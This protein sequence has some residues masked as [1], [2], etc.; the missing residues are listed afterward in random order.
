MQKVISVFG[1]S[2][3]VEES[4]A[5]L[6]AF[7]VGKQLAEAGYAVATG[8]Y[9]GTMG[10]VSHGAASVGGHVI[11]VT[12]GQIEAQFGRLP[13]Q[14]IAEEIKYP[15]LRERLFHL[16]LHND[17]MIALPGGIGT[18]SELSLAW[19]FMQTGEMGKRPFIL[20]GNS[21]RQT[22]EAFY[23]P[24]YTKEADLALVQYA[25]TAGECVALLKK[26]EG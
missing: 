25:E 14:W 17:G 18:L 4:E 11:G 22:I 6:T 12:S 24:E 8:G 20:L 9:Y 26:A 15:T 21:W 16:V 10:A 7:A 23:Q 19:S 5:Y 3:P 2:Q 13:N 1:S